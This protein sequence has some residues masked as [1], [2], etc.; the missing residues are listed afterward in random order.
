MLTTERDVMKHECDEELGPLIDKLQTILS[1]FDMKIAYHEDDYMWSL[2]DVSDN[3][4][5]LFPWYYVS[6]HEMLFGSTFVYSIFDIRSLKSQ[7]LE[8]PVIKV[9]KSLKSDSPEELNIKIDL[10]C[11]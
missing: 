5:L 2:D 7:Y 3:P 4:S 1:R 6:R 10:N 11:V 8:L 9:L